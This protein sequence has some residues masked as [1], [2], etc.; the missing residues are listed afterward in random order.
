MANVFGVQPPNGMQ[1]VSPLGAA[2]SKPAA[3]VAGNVTD[4]V[5]LSPVGQLA[6]KIHDAS[7]IRTDLVQHVQSEIKADSYITPEKIDVTVDRLLEEL[8]GF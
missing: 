6:A 4:T 1:G 7:M 3:P 2:Q 5:E 8:T